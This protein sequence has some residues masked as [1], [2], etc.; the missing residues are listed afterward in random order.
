MTIYAEDV[1][2]WQSSNTSPHTWMDRTKKTI[3]KTAE[4]LKVS[5]EVTGEV[6]GSFESKAAFVFMF[7]LGEDRFKIQWPVL[8]TKSGKNQRSAEIQ[9]ATA[10][11][12]D[13]K[14][15]CVT[16]LV[17]GPRTAFFSYLQLPDGRTVA[18]ASTP[19][20]MRAMLP[21]LVGTNESSVVEG[22]YIVGEE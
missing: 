16:A 5:F 12:R 3:E 6:F 21:L 8:K 17:F 14:Q 18:E 15:K 10:L 2:Y 22:D 19:E 20:L 4:K 9:A 11:Y 1:N 7:R 13:V